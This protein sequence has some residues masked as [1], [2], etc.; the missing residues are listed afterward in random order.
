[1]CSK[2]ISSPVKFTFDLSLV[3]VGMAQ[4]LFVHNF[5]PIRDP[6]TKLNG[7]LR[8]SDNFFNIFTFSLIFSEKLGLVNIM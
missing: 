8:L 3:V 7:K 1:M 6:I 5:I 4:F 2:A